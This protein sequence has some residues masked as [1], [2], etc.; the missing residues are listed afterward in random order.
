MEM[1]SE[2]LCFTDKNI[3]ILMR[4]FMND[5]NVHFII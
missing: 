2:E 5:Y 4:D 1:N 3:K